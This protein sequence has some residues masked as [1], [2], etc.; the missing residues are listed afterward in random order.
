MSRNGNGVYTLVSGNPVVTG[1]V[2]TS[3]WANNTLTD[4]AAALTDSVAADGQ[5]PMTGDLDLNTNKIVNLEP[6]TVAGNAIEYSQFE[7]ATSSS[8]NITGGT[9][10]DTPIGSVTPATGRFTTLESTGDLTSGGDLSVAG[11]G[12]F[13]GTGSLKVP[14]GT[15]AERN[16]VL[17]GS[18]RFNTTYGRFEGC[19]A[20]TAGQTITSIT[21]VATLATLTTATDHGLSTGDIIAVSGATPAAFNG[22]FLIT[23]TSATEFTYV[24]ATTPAN[25][26]TVV[27]S[28]VYGTWG[29]VGGGAGGGGDDEVFVENTLVVTTSYTLPTGKNAS[30]VGPITINSGQTVTIPSAQRWVIL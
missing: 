7:A 11:D 16:S 10:D 9:I 15:I 1:T 4:I 28:Y 25:N 22:T 8:V 29:A 20:V 24:M 23:V 5:T 13:L 27:G 21:R 26:A 3:T 14:T 30:S 17:L 19:T 12:V 6:G 2:I 18:F